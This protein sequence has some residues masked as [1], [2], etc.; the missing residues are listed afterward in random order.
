[1][2][3]DSPAGQPRGLSPLFFTEMWERFSFYGMRAFFALFMGAQLVDGGLGYTKGQAGAVL[4]MYMSMVYMMS[5]PGG[6][7]AD[8]YLGQRRAV[9]LGGAIIMLGHILLAMPSTLVFYLGL[10]ALVIGTGFLKPNVSTMVG[11]LYTK[12]DPRRDGGFSIFYM[13]INVGAF[14]SP[15]VCG[16]LAQSSSFK[17]FLAGHG[18]NPTS[19]W[20]FGFAAAAVGMFAGLI[21]FHLGTRNLKGIGD[22]PNITD[23]RERSRNLRTLGTIVA[24]LLAGPVVLSA[25]HYTGTYELNQE[26]IANIFGVVLLLLFVGTF[27]ALY[28]KANRSERLGVLAMLTLSIGAIAFFALF[29]QAAGTM[30]AFAD[31][32]THN[33]AFG[34]KIESSWYQS[35]NSVFIILLSPL[36]A[37]YFTKL[38]TRKVPFNDIKKFGVALICM[39][40]AFVIMIP[41]ADSMELVS[42]LYLVGFY[43]MSTVAELFLSPVGLSSMSKLA[44]SSAGGLVMGVWFLATANGDY[45]AG[46]VHGLT[47]DVALKPLFI[48]LVIAVFAVAALM[49]V[50]GHYFTHK[51]PL[52]SLMRGPDAEPAPDTDDV[53]VPKAEVVKDASVSR[54]PSPPPT[55]SISGNAIAGFATAVAVW[56]M[57]LNDPKLGG[58]T[59]ALLGPSAI[60]LALRGLT[61]VKKNHVGGGGYAKATVPIAVAA[62]LYT[63]FTLFFSPSAAPAKTPPQGSEIVE[64]AAPAGDSVEPRAPGPA[65][66][67]PDRAPTP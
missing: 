3:Q 44:P 65:E 63:I 40:L 67:V 59:V 51:V 22:P 31:E 24:A 36:F 49:F 52:E 46:R 26:R 29:E 30:T 7:I 8:K 56:P 43:F 60:L 38:A 14:V 45:I 33:F 55:N 32:R 2:S 21:I 1:M 4:A 23:P 16:Y 18:I 19:S 9:F 61:E 47:G 37:W 39:G 25:L 35:I 64:P 5:L 12:R 17:E 66:H 34:S 28:L 6:W 13:G 48:T 42:P 20:H 50:V 10:I 27:T 62:G 15:I 41:A 57:V 11:Q 53:K 58:L 54:T